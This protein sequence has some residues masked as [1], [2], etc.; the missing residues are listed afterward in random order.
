M[1]RKV[2]FAA[3]AACL[4]IST[5]WSGASS[6]PGVKTSERQ[7]RAFSGEPVCAS[8]LPAGLGG[9]TVGRSGSAGQTQ[10]SPPQSVSLTLADS[11]RMALEANPDLAVQALVPEMDSERIALAREK[12]LP[13]FGLSSYYYNQDYPNTWGLQGPVISYKYDNYAFSVAQL[14]PTST[15]ITL[16][17][18]NGMV[19][20]SQQFMLVNPAYNSEFRLELRQPLLKDFGPRIANYETTKARRQYD[21]SRAAL[22]ATLLD[23]IY[24]VEYAYW[25]LYYARQNLAVLEL[26]LEQSRETLKQNREA[27][28]I[29]S[30][31][32]FDVLGSETQVASYED[33]VLAARLQ[34]QNQENQ[35]KLLLGMPAN[36]TGEKGSGAGSQEP[37]VSVVPIDKPEV[38]R[39]AVTYEDALG[40]ALAERPE[41]AEYQAQ[42]AGAAADLSYYR[43]Q[44]LPQLDVNFSIWSPGQS[45]I[46]FIFEGDN[47]F[48]P[49]I[50]RVVGSRWDSFRDIWRWH[51]N[52]MNFYVTFSLPLGNVISRAGVAVARL[53]RDQ[54]VLQLDKQRKSIQLEVQ[55]AVREIEVN[56]RRVESSTRYR[57]AAEKRVTAEQERY[58]LGLVGNEWLF[59]YQRDLASAKAGEIRA[60]IDYKISLA[61]LDQATGASITAKGL[62]F[63]DY[64]F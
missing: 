19:N 6:A 38:E 3:L 59:Q 43:N 60:I 1:R 45:G 53:A 31:S 5:L 58:N 2:L 7:A 24:N 37:P 32:A 25:N 41:L 13:L 11:I 47:P 35:L 63:K 64:E 36:G 49:I 8:P 56:A 50:G 23:T 14:L 22:K 10:P 9:Q 18:S 44:S 34:I 61:K 33:S 12:F 52:N 27:A 26:S 40:I 57:E 16:S 20:T 51:Y 28:R 54:A 42:I 62:K 48:N 39:R 30:R 55:Q 21:A 15:Q 4:L 29:G 46:R 17:L